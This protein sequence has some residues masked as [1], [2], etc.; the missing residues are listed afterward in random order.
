[1][2]LISNFLVPHNNKLLCMIIASMLLVGCMSNEV[3]TK[4]LDIDVMKYNIS[5]V[6]TDEANINSLGEPAPL[7]VNIFNLRS[8]SEFMNADFFTLH[9][10]PSEILGSKLLSSDQV[11]ISPN[12][13]TTDIS[14]EIIGEYSYV[15]ISGEFQNFNNKTWRVIV[16]IVP[17]E[18]IPFYKFWRSAPTQQEIHV[19]INKQGLNIVK[20]SDEKK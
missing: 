9:N 2:K 4:K 12:S 11:F 19:V 5:I 18:K 7:K 15:G 20:D 3:S 10:K 8:E 13:K 6:A 1:M 16:P 17:P 14:G